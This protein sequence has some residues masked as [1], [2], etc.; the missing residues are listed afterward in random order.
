MRLLCSCFVEIRYGGTAMKAR[1]NLDRWI[2]EH[3]E[4][5]VDFLVKM[6]RIP[7]VT[8]QEGKI[9]SFMAQSLA[10]NG[11]MVDVF[12][13]SMDEL[14]KHPAFV[15]PQEGYAGR[16]NVVG[17]LK[18]SGGG[19]SLLFNGHT[20][21]IPEG[22]AG[23][24]HHGPWSGDIEE[25][26]I[27]GRGASDMK[28]GAA[29]MTMAIRAVQQS[30]LR[31]KG[32]V[33][34]EY[35]IDE[36]LTGNG[37]L[38]CVLKGYQADAG[39]CCETSS[40]CIQPGSI[41]RIWFE[42]RVKGKSAGIQKHYEGV[43]AIELG[44]QVQ[45]AVAAF[46]Q[47]RM[48]RI[49]HPLYPDIRSSIPCMIGSFESGSYASAFP[50][51]CLLKGSLAT[52]PGENSEKVKAEF[53]RYITEEAAAGSVWMKDH[54]PEIVFTGYFAEPSE[55]SV[56]EPIVHTL[57]EQYQS[58]LGRVPTISGRQGAADIRHLNQY[59]GTPTVIFGP[60]LTEQ[61]HANNEWVY[62]EDYLNAIRVLAHTIITWC[63][64]E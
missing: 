57:V 50:D 11:L 42:I 63:G 61:M 49:S 60:G 19:R 59:G 8:G 5:L 32:D 23:N 14:R 28:S 40:M 52:V 48:E 18:G 44:Y 41:G 35:V 53:V 1:E 4:E 55:I 24:W 37:T 6:L 22:A 54:P 31:L 43:N 10:E 9:Q 3:E 56:D 26:K 17:I 38:A 46:E 25:G 12:E 2:A 62:R 30:G 58:L 20:D 33:I 39:I 15:E 34:A 7:S 51:E 29:A 27:Y 64:V 45:Q 47:T 13:P 36:E 21:V 16:P